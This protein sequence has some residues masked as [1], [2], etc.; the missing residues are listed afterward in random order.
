MS[1]RGASV[2]IWTPC[3]IALENECMMLMDMMVVV[4]YEDIF[5]PLEG[6]VMFCILILCC[7]RQEN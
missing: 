1:M 3:I 7:V 5:E 6:L 2:A 4:S